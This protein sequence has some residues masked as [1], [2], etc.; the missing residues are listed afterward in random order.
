M[1]MV[2]YI[3]TLILS[4]RV[5]IDMIPTFLASGIILYGIIQLIVALIAVILAVRWNRYEFLPGLSFILLYAIIEL[6]DLFFFTVINSMFID[7]AQFGFIL[8]AVIFFIIGMHPL[9][10]QKLLPG[11]KGS[12]DENKPSGESVFSLI[13][14]I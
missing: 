4:H 10:S 11:K 1:P 12:P 5:V 13:K 3:S 7:V 6:I 9:W 2:K 8:I 14:K